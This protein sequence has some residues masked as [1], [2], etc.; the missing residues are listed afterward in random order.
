[1]S[2]QKNKFGK[3]LALYL[4]LIMGSSWT[5][6]VTPIWSSEEGDLVSTEKATLDSAGRKD[7]FKPFMDTA[8]DVMKKQKAKG[9]LPLSP[10]QRQDLSVFNLVGISGNDQKG[11]KAIVEDGEKKFYPI[12]EGTLIGLDQGRVSSIKA[13]RVIVA[14]KSADRKVK[15]NYITIMLHKDIEGTP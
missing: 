6:A 12:V 13:D 7:P 5:V 4:V 8:T 15:T 9:A 11:W 2:R 1:M 14:V 3:V 10:L